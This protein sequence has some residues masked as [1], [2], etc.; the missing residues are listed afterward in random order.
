VEELT[1]HVKGSSSDPYELTFIKDGSSLTAL[2]NCPAGTFGNLCKHRV[3]IL[4]GD[5]SAV[6]D[7]DGGKTGSV[8]EWLIGTD[9]EAALTEM[10]QVETTTG[11]PKSDLVAAKRKLAK[12]M[13]S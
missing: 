1:L 11:T 12:A 3:A 7:D 10:R 4:D 2:C 5:S 13:N 6:V 9:V 8:V